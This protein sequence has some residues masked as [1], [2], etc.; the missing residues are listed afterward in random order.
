LAPTL[1]GP[2]SASPSPCAPSDYR[3]HLIVYARYSSRAPT[4]RKVCRSPCLWLTGHVHLHSLANGTSR[5]R[6]SLCVAFVLRAGV[7]ALVAHSSR[8]AQ[9]PGQRA[10]GC[11]TCGPK[12]LD[13]INMMA[14]KCCVTPILS[15]LPLRSATSPRRYPTPVYA[16]AYRLL[17]LS[18]LPYLK[19][20]IGNLQMLRL[21]LYHDHPAGID[22]RCHSQSEE[23]Q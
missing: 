6:F 13:S 1:T 11:L 15:P 19:K 10:S 16:D 5:N 2:S 7:A 18:L 9:R 3:F 22:L 20:R 17:P 12:I 23:C 8:V 14:C 21:S 4:S